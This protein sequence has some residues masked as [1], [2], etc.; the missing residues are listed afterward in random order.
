MFREDRLQKSSREGPARVVPAQA[1]TP[2]SSWV[3]AFAGTT[4]K[5]HGNDD[6]APRERRSSAGERRSNAT[7]TTIKRRG[8]DD[9]TPPERRSSAA[10]TT[11]ERFF[12]ASLAVTIFN[13]EEP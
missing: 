3:P 5:R 1:G 12:R 4:I 10:G 13:K 9:Q 6:Q 11:I 2:F 8:N 7:G